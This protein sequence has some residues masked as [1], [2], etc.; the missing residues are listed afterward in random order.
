MVKMNISLAIPSLVSP[1]HANALKAAC[2]GLVG[3]FPG[4]EICG[5]LLAGSVAT[6]QSTTTSDID[7]FVAV[8]GDWSQRRRE[9]ISGSEI[10]VFIDGKRRLLEQM[11][12][13]GNPITVRA[14]ASGC[15]L[16]DPNGFMVGAQARAKTT[17]QGRRRPPSEGDEFRQ[18]QRMKDSLRAFRRAVAEC[19]RFVGYYLYR[20]IEA[21]CEASY[22][23]GNRWTTSSREM[24]ADIESW[25]PEI[26]RWLVALCE[27]SES[28]ESKIALA[29]QFV[30]RILHLNTTAAARTRNAKTSYQRNQS[31]LEIDGKVVVIP[32]PG[33]S[34]PGQRKR[35]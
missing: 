9:K 16:Y 21:G 31:R 7:L 35:L 28:M 17:L 11:Q 10:D 29:E 3:E 19:N 23:L 1:L 14:Y 13:A 25:N 5:L 18:V 22:V 32:T 6:A 24:F 4:S 2:D 26:H 12:P 27:E 30:S 20:L 15:V 34:T 33:H 8:E